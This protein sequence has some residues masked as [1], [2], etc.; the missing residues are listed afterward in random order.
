[1]KRIL[2]LILT[3]GLII[4]LVQISSASQDITV[5]VNNQKVTF[6]DQKPYI[7]QN[8]RTMVPVRFVSEAL[9]AKVSWNGKTQTVGIVQG[10]KDIALKIGESKASVNDQLALFDTKAVLVNSRTMVPLRFVSETLGAQ[11]DWVAATSTVKITVNNHGYSLPR[12]KSDLSIDVPTDNDNPNKVD[13][14]LNVLMYKP[15]EPQY[16]DLQNILAS[17]YGTKLAQEITDY[18]KTKKDRFDNLP[19]RDWTVNNQIIEVASQSGAVNVNILI[20][21]PGV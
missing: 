4:G 13:I 11:V 17:K 20:W 19:D 5:L 10:G 18:V 3:F 15:L 6:P 8:N 2:A 16:T 12:G 1:M 9:G 14:D 21:L 7:D